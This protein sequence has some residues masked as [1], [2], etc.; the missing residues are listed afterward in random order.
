MPVVGGLTL[1]MMR[2]NDKLML[3][4]LRQFGPKVERRAIRKALK[5]ASAVILKRAKQLAPKRTG[6]LRRALAVSRGRRLKRYPDG[7]F[8]AVVGPAWFGGQHGHLVERGTTAR[9]FKGA[10]RGR[11]PAQP[12]L[13]PAYAEKIDAARDKL[14]TVIKT[15]VEK[16]G[17]QLTRGVNRV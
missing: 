14:R 2:W 9:K 5:A 7:G 4:R 8:L 15:E 11:M 3:R 10:S 6:G 16:A 17:R 13:K 12:F 1:R